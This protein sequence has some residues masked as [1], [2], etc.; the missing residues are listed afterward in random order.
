MNDNDDMILNELIQIAEEFDKPK[1][2]VF[3]GR[4]RG[5]KQ[6]PECKVYIGVRHK[7]CVCK[8]TFK[9]KREPV[10][11]ALSPECIEARNF[12][13][14]LGYTPL[15]L[16]IIFTPRGKCPVKFKGDM[17]DWADKVIERYY[18]DNYVLAPT[19]LVYMIGQFSRFNSDEYHQNK[20]DLKDWIEGIKNESF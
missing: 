8:H 7:V 19:A 13:A 6:C 10:P 4:G 3:D 9:K 15:G 17:A 1:I 20:E 14:A 2:N 18:G 5:R 16:S 11:E 12:I